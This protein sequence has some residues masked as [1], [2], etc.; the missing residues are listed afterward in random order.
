MQSFQY[1]YSQI[2]ALWSC[3][4]NIKYNKNHAKFPELPKLWLSG[5]M[6][7]VNII[8]PLDLDGTS[9]LFLESS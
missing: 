3:S 5:S 8:K 4:I 6:E 9:E 1:F 7:V 2:L